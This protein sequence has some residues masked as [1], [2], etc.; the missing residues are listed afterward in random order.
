MGASQP[1]P[2]AQPP[3]AP[4]RSLRAYSS[5][6]ALCAGLL[7]LTI[8]GLYRFA[9]RFSVDVKAL[10]AKEGP[11]EILTFVAASGA[12]IVL[13]SA[14]RKALAAAR[15]LPH[16]RIAAHFYFVTAAIKEV[17]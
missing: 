14:G 2:A 4:T 15:L 12:S 17:M 9:G 5:A 10:F 8:L 6:L 13:V 11:L 3:S 7:G 1:R 16:A